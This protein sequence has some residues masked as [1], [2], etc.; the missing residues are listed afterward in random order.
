MFIS[1][2]GK[3]GMGKKVDSYSFHITIMVGQ[4]RMEVFLILIHLKGAPY[5]RTMVGD[6]C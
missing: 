3:K 1:S 5:S 6:L 4:H 2:W